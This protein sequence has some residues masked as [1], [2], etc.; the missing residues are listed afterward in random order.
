[1][2]KKDEN[3]DHT[4]TECNKLAQNYYKTI[5]DWVVEVIHW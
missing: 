3:I 5:D 4:I 2:W 1:M